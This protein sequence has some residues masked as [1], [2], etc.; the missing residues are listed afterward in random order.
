M[1]YIVPP[2]LDRKTFEADFLRDWTDEELEVLRAQVKK[3]ARH[4]AEE[5]SKRERQRQEEIEHCGERIPAE[6]RKRLPPSPDLWSKFRLFSNQ[7]RVARI[8]QRMEQD[9]E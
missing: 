2:P 4:N 8:R 7:V 9:D 5:H 6:L 3:A 1:G